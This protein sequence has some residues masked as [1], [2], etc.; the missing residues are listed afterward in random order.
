M[1]DL[2][3]LMHLFRGDRAQVREWIGL[4]L[5]EAPTYFDELFASSRSGDARTMANASHDLQA[6]AHYLGAPRMLELLI[7]IEEQAVARGAD[8]CGELLN[9]LLPLREAIDHELRAV[10]NAS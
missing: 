7:A 3:H 5:Q 2:S 6:Q 10:L 4:Y 1:I 8:S 9:A